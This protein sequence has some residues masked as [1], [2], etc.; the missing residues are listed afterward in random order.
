MST[1]NSAPRD[2]VS[3]TFTQWMLCDGG[4]WCWPLGSE[5]APLLAL[6]WEVPGQ[7]QTIVMDAPG[8][9]THCDAGH[10]LLSLL[11]F[12]LLLLSTYWCLASRDTY[13]SRHCRVSGKH[14]EWGQAALL[15]A[16]LFNLEQMASAP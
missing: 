7:I 5:A 4:A 9:L 6:S 16:L 1:N 2:D 13:P 12:V 11:I 14:S 3:D 15:R 8:Q 10:L